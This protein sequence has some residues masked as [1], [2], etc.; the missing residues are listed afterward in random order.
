[1]TATISETI[2][3]RIRNRRE[4]LG[5]SQE[6]LA[7][8]IGYT[9]RSS[10]NKIETGAQQLRQ[11]KIKAV[12]DALD[13]TVNYILVIDTKADSQKDYLDNYMDQIKDI[14]SEMDDAQ[15]ENALRLSRTYLQMYAEQLTK[16]KLENLEIDKK[17]EKEE[18]GE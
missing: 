16:L 13:T 18:E 12:A 15:K 1:M 4:L 5:L 11:S 2:G 9:S 3:D 6:D 10:I 8:M 17:A 7:R 14:I